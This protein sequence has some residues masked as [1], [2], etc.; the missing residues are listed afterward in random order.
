MVLAA[1][2]VSLSSLFIFAAFRVINNLRENGYRSES[3]GTNRF[4]CVN[5]N[6][7]V[8]RLGNGYCPECQFTPLIKIS[9][10]EYFKK[11]QSKDLEILEN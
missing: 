10:E 9:E 6:M 5:C 7:A 8:R 3:L 2:V 11:V 4:Y 1:I